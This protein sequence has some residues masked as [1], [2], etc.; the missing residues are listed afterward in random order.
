MMKKKAM[1]KLELAKET[2]K[3]LD[4]QDLTEAMGGATTTPMRTCQSCTCDL[5]QQT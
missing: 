1:K 2:V 5:C 3:K 4:G